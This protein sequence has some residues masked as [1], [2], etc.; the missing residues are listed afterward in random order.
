VFLADYIDC[1]GY[2]AETVALLMEYSKK[3]PHWVF[4]KGNHEQMMIDALSDPN[5]FDMWWYQ[6]GRETFES[7][8]NR[9]NLS[10][11]ERSIIQPDDAIDKKHLEWLDSL[12]LFYE[13]Q[14][15]LFVHAGFI[16]GVP[17]EMNPPEAMMWI[18]DEFISSPYSWGKRVI[19]GH[20]YHPQPVVMPNKILI[21]CVHH[22]G[23]NLTA[24]VL[25]ET[26]PEWY[27]FI[28][29]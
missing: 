13:T 8:R 22:G 23:G 21:D 2:S 25:D 18:R 12:P 24:V 1:G 16:P 3:Y 14:N 15:F 10:P 17:L 6:G 4:L 7:Y 28:T 20:T 11:Y 9:M 5:R 29:S 27:H 19:A 26:R